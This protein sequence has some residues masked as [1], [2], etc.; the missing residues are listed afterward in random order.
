MQLNFLNKLLHREPDYD[1]KIAA[2]ETGRYICT[3]CFK[4]LDYELLTPLEMT[5]C[6]YCDDLFIVPQ[7]LDEWWVLAPL[8]AGGMGAVYMARHAKKPN[9]QAAVKVL[10]GN[11][12]NKSF[13][14]L[15]INEAKVAYSFG[16]H[17]NLSQV[18]GYGY[19]SDSAY[20]IMAIVDGE[21]LDN[22]I[23][24]DGA[25]DSELCLYYMHDL[26][27]ALKH[28]YDTG[29]LYRDLKPEN[30]IINAKHEAILID[31][32][33]CMTLDEAWHYAEDDIMGSPLYMPPERVQGC[34]EDARA[35]LYSLGMVIYHS[36]KGKPYFTQTE[37]MK[38]VQSHLQTLR[39][40]TKH[41]LSGIDENVQNLIDRL[42]RLD[43]DERLN[44]YDVVLEHV[45]QLLSYFKD[46]PTK[47]KIVMQRRKMMFG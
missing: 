13:L 2:L 16:K 25:I 40:Q 7:K 11:E 27:L 30:I 42:I 9:I 5:N 22:I 19:K 44:D 36:L 1:Q 33:L 20:M 8:G 18:Y 31:Y 37:V 34:G 15:L 14:E 28:I 26:I 10:Q 38:I 41:K 32:G 3:H 43:R 45:N 39:V 23:S 24:R 46:I 47:N 35:D 17:H 4:E 6:P 12:Q 29:Y 21:R